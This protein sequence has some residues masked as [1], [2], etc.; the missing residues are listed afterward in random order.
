MK[1][2]IVLI[3]SLLL[4]F[5][6]SGC[7]KNPDPTT[8]DGYVP[9]DQILSQNEAISAVCSGET[10][11]LSQDGLELTLS[12]EDTLLRRNGL[13]VGKTAALPKVI[14]G[15]VFLPESFITDYLGSGK[16]SLFYG[17]LF[18][19]GEILDAL[20]QPDASQFSRLLL[21]EILLPTSMDIDAPHVDMSRVFIS[22]P[23]SKYPDDLLNEIHALL[24]YTTDHTY[25]Y[26]E[27]AVLTGNLPT[28]PMQSANEL[29]DTDK[30][31]S[32][33]L[34]IQPWD[35][36][37]LN[38]VYPGTYME[39]PAEVLKAALEAYYAVDIT[40]LEGLASAY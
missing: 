34:N 27:Y 16:P 17:A 23:L 12:T 4:L 38:R 8:P 6:L 13:I 40:Y 11:T 31:F 9:L 10:I 29:H 15:T 30:I 19:P 21:E 37:Y 3:L 35:I 36:T 28:S 14:S 18:F 22:T 26:T 39:Q 32:E 7:Q 25:Y 24:G 33:K 2:L 5:S 20:E 1:K